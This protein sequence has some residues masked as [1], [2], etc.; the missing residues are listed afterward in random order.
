MELWIESSKEFFDFL[1]LGNLSHMD[2]LSIFPNI[3]LDIG[4][5]KNN[6]GNY[7]KWSCYICCVSGIYLLDIQSVV[8]GGDSPVIE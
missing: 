8:R 2:F 4:M 5:R 6:N 7:Q 1:K 3:Y